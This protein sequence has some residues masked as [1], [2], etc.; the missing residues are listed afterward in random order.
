MRLSLRQWVIVVRED[1]YPNFPDNLS[2]RSITRLNWCAVRVL[3]MCLLRDYLSVTS[4]HRAAWDAAEPLRQPVSAYFRECLSC[5]DG[6]H[7]CCCFDAI[8]ELILSF[9]SLTTAPQIGINLYRHMR[10]LIV[11][12]YQSLIVA[13][14]HDIFG[15]K[16]QLSPRLMPTYTHTYYISA[17][18]VSSAVSQCCWY[19]ILWTWF[20]WCSIPV[21]PSTP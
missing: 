5:H 14:H 9:N 16:T 8:L 4:Y 18:P 21:I 2:W 7:C 17:L 11:T 6:W 19:P 13:L 10:T 1:G 12:C 3:S 15:T 20:L